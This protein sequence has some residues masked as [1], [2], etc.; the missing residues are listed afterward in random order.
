MNAWDK[1]DLTPLM[2]AA[3]NNRNPAVTRTLLDA[4]ANVKARNQFGA[5]ALNP[6]LTGSAAFRPLQ[7][8]SP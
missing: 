5:T 3:S 2:M 4:G 7:D 1:D 6:A 8:A